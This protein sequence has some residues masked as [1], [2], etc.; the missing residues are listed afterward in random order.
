MFVSVLFFF[1][2]C[3]KDEG[4]K[5]IPDNTIRYNGKNYSLAFAFGMNFGSFESGVGTVNNTD[6][7]F[8]DRAIDV[9]DDDPVFSHGFYLELFS[10][11]SADF[12]GGTF[13]YYNGSGS[14]PSGL[15]EYAELFFYDEDIDP[16]EVSGGTVEV[17][18]SGN[19]YKFVFDM[20]TAEG[21]KLEGNF[22]GTIQIQ[23]VGGSNISGNISVNG[24]EKSADY[25]EV[26]DW[27]HDG[28][29]YNYDFT[30]YDSDDTYELYFEAFSLGTSGF[31]AG[32]FNYNAFGSSYFS[33]IQYI[34]YEEFI[35]FEAIG[36]SVVVTKLS[37][38]YEYRLVFD[39]LLDD[40]SE[41]TGTVEGNFDYYNFGGR[42]G[43]KSAHHSK[44]IQT[45]RQ[46][47]HNRFR[48]NK[49]SLRR[50]KK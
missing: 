47:E 6:F 19:N 50:I 2:S 42:E 9:E 38:T 11:G 36:G 4:E 18:I 45:K 3:S 26:V 33:N 46:K 30:M 17:T 12:H 44:G 8:V 37:G 24:A 25:G 14:L 23:D 43:G 22:S 41:L 49:S 15:F 10:V 16:I 13:S 31:Q 34:D 32:T 35:D 20:T 28:S 48:V 5:G 1:S 29:H 39:V 27:G 40:E 7:I 21:K